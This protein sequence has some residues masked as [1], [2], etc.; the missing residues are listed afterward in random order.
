M[1]RQPSKLTERFEGEDGDSLTVCRTNWGEPFRD[2][3]S[4]EFHNGLSDYVNVSLE[5]SELRL[6]HALL[7]R[8]LERQR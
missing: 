2:G 6:L 3:A 5:T 1:K 7:G 8:L 4:F